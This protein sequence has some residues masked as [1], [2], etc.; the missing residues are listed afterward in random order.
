MHCV[1]LLISVFPWSKT[2]IA[3]FHTRLLAQ[4][5][6]V[7]HRHVTC[8]PGRTCGTFWH[9]RL[10]G[11]R[12]RRCWV[13]RFCYASSR[14]LNKA[15]ASCEHSCGLQ[16]GYTVAQWLSTDTC[17]ILA[18]QIAYFVIQCA[19]DFA[20]FETQGPCEQL[21]VQFFLAFKVRFLSPSGK[22]REN[23]PPGRHWRRRLALCARIYVV[24][25]LFCVFRFF[26]TNMLSAMHV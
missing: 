17:A 14:S 9:M 13:V 21:A 2:I 8:Y 3:G 15:Q 5:T 7:Q 24:C 6:M 4:L 26:S 19:R 11:W 12:I 25:L 10:I 1:R 22:A 18:C 16:T 20:D 23:A